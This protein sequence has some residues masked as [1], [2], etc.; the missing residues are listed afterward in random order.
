MLVLAHYD[1]VAAITCLHNEFGVPLDGVSGQLDCGLGGQTA[2]HLAV[3]GNCLSAVRWV[4]SS[5][6]MT[7]TLPRRWFLQL[8][9]DHTITNQEGRTPWAVA[10]RYDNHEVNRR[11]IVTM[12]EKEFHISS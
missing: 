4:A 12:M 2:L 6:I 1:N 9:A 11:D 7:H 8:G 3:D 10:K 5:S